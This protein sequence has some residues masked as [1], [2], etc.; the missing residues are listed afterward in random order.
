MI[1]APNYTNFYRQIFKIFKF[2]FHGWHPE[3]KE[4]VEESYQTPIL[5]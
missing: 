1:I 5:C 4:I 2:V 3:K